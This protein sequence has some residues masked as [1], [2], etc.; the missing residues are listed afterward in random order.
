MYNSA[1]PNSLDGLLADY[2][3]RNLAQ[4][5][6]MTL[7]K[8][9]SDTSISRT[10]I[11]RFFSRGGYESFEQFLG[12]LIEE[13]EILRR[14]QVSDIPEKALSEYYRNFRIGSG[15]LRKM[16]EALAAADTVVFG[17]DPD[18]PECLR[19]TSYSLLLRGTNVVYMP[20]WDRQETLQR[21]RSL[22]GKDAIFIFDTFH[23]ISKYHEI[24]MS[25]PAL[26]GIKEL[27]EL[28]CRKFYVGPGRSNNYQD[29]ESI[30]FPQNPD[31]CQLEKAGLRRLDRQ[32]CEMLN[33]ME[34]RR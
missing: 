9:I 18:E 6:E 28:T 20:V 26:V 19:N 34:K 33:G 10:S 14:L 15:D 32:L 29:F 1:P 13:Y 31:S 4:V 12:E 16:A 21:L 11:Y 5:H 17:G 30:D 23:R 27:S 3:L 7:K 22:K 24:I 25:Y 8:C 2:F